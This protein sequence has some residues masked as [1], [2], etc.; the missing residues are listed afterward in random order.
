[1]IDYRPKIFLIH[2][3]DVNLSGLLRLKM[4][5][6]IEGLVVYDEIFKIK[7]WLENRGLIEKETS[8]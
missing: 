2:Y 7:L 5:Y 8:I 1:M 6:N 3:G 4:T